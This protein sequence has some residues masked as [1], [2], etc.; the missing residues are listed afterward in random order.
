M[1][2]QRID[3]I[4]ILL[5]DDQPIVRGGLTLLLESYPGWELVGQADSFGAARALIARCAV[6][7]LLL[8]LS[9]GST[10]RLEHIPLLL[11]AAPRA[12]VVVLAVPTIP[13]LRAQVAAYGG[14]AVVTTRQSIAT[15]L[16]A[17]RQ[18][19]PDRPEYG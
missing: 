16:D 18:A 10:F 3:P 11:A 12:R 9:P 17:I 6:D 2:C 8:S 14:R 4:R 1:Q 15:L 19:C 13:R 5:L 7:I